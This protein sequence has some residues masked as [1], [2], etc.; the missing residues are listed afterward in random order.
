MIVDCGSLGRTE[1]DLD[2][3]QTRTYLRTILAQHQAAPNVVV[4]HAD[5]DHYNQTPIRLR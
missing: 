1:V 5:P 3:Q 2:A 4:S